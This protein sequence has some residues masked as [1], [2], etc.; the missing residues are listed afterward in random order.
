MEFDHA[1]LTIVLA[2]AEHSSADVALLVEDIQALITASLWASFS[3]PDLSDETL[4][5]A[6]RILLEGLES[7][8]AGVRFYPSF[9]QILNVP[10][11]IPFGQNGDELVSQTG[12]GDLDFR[13]DDALDVGTLVGVNS[14]MRRQVL[15]HDIE[16]YRKVFGFATIDRLEHH[17]PLVIEVGIALTSAVAVP[18][19][20]TYGLLR[21]VAK[22]KRANAEA[23][24]R[25]AEAD[26]RKEIV[27]QRKVQTEI[28]SEV[29]DAIKSERSRNEDFHV[30]DEVL[31]NAAKIAEPVVAELGSSSLIEKVTFG[32]SFGGKSE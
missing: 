8:K 16:L 7:A 3:S 23:E 26:D 18:I 30:P 10:G 28:I 32:A 24:I 6:K 25:Q 31:V 19:L 21:A 2:N 13:S 20:L 9:R 4:L 11:L 29:R 15:A 12:G 14:W 27:K 5:K 22:A 17:S 1:S